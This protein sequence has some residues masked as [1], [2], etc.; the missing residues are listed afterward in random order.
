M[1]IND[2]S[3][4]FLVLYVDDILL[5]SYDLTPL[6]ESIYIY[7]LYNSYNMKNLG[8]FTYLFDIEIRCERSHG[9]LGLSQRAYISMV[10]ERFFMQAYKPEKVLIA[11][12]NKFSKDK[13][14]END[15]EKKSM[16]DGHYNNI[17]DS[18]MYAHVLDQTLPFLSMFLAYICPI[19]EGNT[20]LL[21]RR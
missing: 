7:M 6:H 17:I 9:L 4:I 14:P 2:T 8:E 11:K 20:G 19:R 12:G 16:K 21:L 15:I 10:L 3:F 13:C 5:A 18:L 1:K